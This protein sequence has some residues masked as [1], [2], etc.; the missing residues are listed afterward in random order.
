MLSP[1]CDNTFAFSST[2]SGGRGPYTYAWTF[3]KNSAADGSGTWS[4][5]S[6]SFISGSATSASGVFQA[7]SQGRYR[8]LLEVKDS[9]APEETPDDPD[10]TQKQQCTA[11]ATSNAIN[12]YYAVGGSISLSPDCDDTFG[13]QAAGSGGKAP[14]SYDFTVERRNSDG[15]YS[16]VGTFQKT[17]TLASPGVSGEL[18][19][20]DYGG[21]GTYRLKVTITDSQGLQCSKDLTSDQI[22]V[23]HELTAS[24]SKTDA[25]RS[26]LTAI[27]TGSSAS[28]ASLQWQIMKNG[29][30]QDISSATS[31]TLNY[32]SF[33]ADATPTTK[34]FMLDG[35][36]FKGQMWSVELRL[37]ASRTLN[38]Q[39]CE[40]FSSAVP[41]K[42]LK[43]VDP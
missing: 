29:S 36:N 13:Y 37:K 43:A 1:Q 41:V 20:D 5:A 30:W 31:E 42:L 15:S 9:A 23:A 4:T 17:D 12:V 8:A 21:A 25:N 26:S 40:A 28:G 24:A 39:L 32:S 2:V 16:D 10:T 11:D 35:F 34:D 33:E 7:A 14:Y 6:G 38:G 27:L 22:D 18:D 3:E 19:I